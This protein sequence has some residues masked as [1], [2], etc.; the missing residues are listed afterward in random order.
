MPSM[1]IVSEVDLHEVVNAVDQANREVKNRYDFKGTNAHF[2]IDKNVITSFAPTGTLLSQMLQT[3]RL[4]LGKRNVD[5][6]SM[7]VQD[8][9]SAGR[10]KKQVMEI[11]Q[12]IDKETAKKMIKMVKGTK[13]KV[14]ASIHDDKVKI[15]GKKRDN[16]QEIIAFFKSSEVGI[17]LQYINF[18]D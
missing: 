5:I 8:S 6:S 15:T 11:S 2:T 12:G 16:L 3:L 7:Q 10:D 4:K 17:P 14:Q 13:L 9:V 18:R 1:D